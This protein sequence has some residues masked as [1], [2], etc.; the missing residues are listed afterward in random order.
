LL[1]TTNTGRS[2]K[3]APAVPLIAL[4]ELWSNELMEEQ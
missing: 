4:Q 2:G 1:I 3:V